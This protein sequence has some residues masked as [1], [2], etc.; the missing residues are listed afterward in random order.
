MLCLLW[1]QEMFKRRV[2]FQNE[3]TPFLKNF[4]KTFLILCYNVLLYFLAVFFHL[5]R[6][7]SKQTKCSLIDINR[8]AQRFL[9]NVKSK[10]ICFFIWHEFIKLC[11]LLKKGGHTSGITWEWEP[12]RFEVIVVLLNKLLYCL[13]RVIWISFGLV[14]VCA[15]GSFNILTN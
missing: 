12:M 14:S 6:L 13:T 7:K 11:A 5:W 4:V 2:W 9:K 8:N 3:I 15:F 1:S 10:V